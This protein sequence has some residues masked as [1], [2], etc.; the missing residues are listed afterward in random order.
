VRIV[1]TSRPWEAGILSRPNNQLAFY[2]VPCTHSQPFVIRY[3]MPQNIWDLRPPVSVEVSMNTTD[4]SSP[5]LSDA[6]IF[7]VTF[8]F[9]RVRCVASQPQ[10]VSD[11]RK[12]RFLWS[13]PIKGGSAIARTW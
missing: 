9:V 8:Q 13:S 3:L 4:T 5:T 6:C 10:M 7:Q 1:S 11:C 2:A 12:N